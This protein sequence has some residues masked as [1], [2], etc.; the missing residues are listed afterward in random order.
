MAKSRKQR[1][2]IPKNLAVKW[3]VSALLIAAILVAGAAVGTVI[4]A[5]INP[6]AWDPEA[7]FG[8]ETTILYDKNG[9]P[10]YNLYFEENRIQVPL[11]S[12]PDDLKNAFLSVEDQQFYEHHG[13]N[14]LAILRAIYV[15]LTKGSLSQGASTITQQLART[16][17]LNPEKT[18]ERKIKEM[19]ISFQLESK[20]SKDEIFKFYI[21]RINFGSGAW[22]VQT[23]SQ[24]YYGKDIEELTLAESA[25]LAGLV[26]RPNAYSPFKNLELAKKRRSIV[27]NR[28]VDCGYITQAEADEAKEEPIKLNEK[29][30]TA[31]RYG[32][33]V[34]YVIDEADRILEELGLYDDPQEVIFKGGL[35]IYT[36]MDPKAQL[37]AE[38]TYA[39]ASSFPQAQSKSG[40]TLQSSMILLDHRTGAIQCLI[41]GREYTHKRGFNRAVDMLRQPGSAFK[42]VVVFGPA[43]EKGYTP[44]YMLEDAPVTYRIGGETWSPGN[45]DGKYRGMI[46]MRTAIQYSVNIYAVKLADQVGIKNG[47]AFA[48]NLGITSLV[49][50][51]RINDM[52]LS[53]ALGGITKGVSPLE[54]ASAYGCFA[55]KGVLAEHHVITK[56]VAKNG[57]TIYTHRPTEKRVMTEATAWMMT[58]MLQNAVRA[59]TGTNARISGVACAGKTGTTQNDRDA[60]FVGYTPNYTSAV[61]M[62][63]D[64]E[65][66]MNKTYGGSYPARIWKAVMS[67]VAT[68]SGNFS[69]PTGI[70]QVAICQKS[71]KLA[72]SACPEEDINLVHMNPKDAPEETCD[73]HYLQK[74]C[75][76][77]GQL[78][79]SLCPDT[80]DKGYLKDAPFDDPQ[81]A[82]HEYCSLHQEQ[83]TPATT[84]LICTDPRHEGKLY[85]ANIP[86]GT[87]FGGCPENMRQ[88]IKLEGSE[89]LVY[90]PLS[91]HQ[92]SR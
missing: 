58:D 2:K 50:A 6:P 10:F 56:I 62:G 70:T 33:F 1:K 73:L 64:K 4:G 76:E 81:A 48:E 39:K 75:S 85:L 35:K 71:G 14:F 24:I 11:S 91:D 63:Y 38:E 15:D 83:V 66:T 40:Q 9:D 21:N 54:L 86:K 34:D 5:I 3:I 23:A 25:L 92:K 42:P 77:S 29:T 59:G 55:N 60:W 37:T 84:A 74:I 26:Q 28:M 18:W 19:V 20:Y 67:T 31:E 88:E 13:I 82:P 43:L 44:G 87:E 41:G 45:Y 68:G 79:T 36:T 80:V 72:S 69:I 16:A 47:I 61:W 30:N 7:L 52:N 78:A 65:E 32:F 49:K 89:S 90:C 57:S 46:T 22:G 8:S 27:L 17:F 51:G 12:V 53:T